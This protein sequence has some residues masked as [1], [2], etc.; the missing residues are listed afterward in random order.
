MASKRRKYKEG[1]ERLIAI[2]A[3]E[4]TITGFL[5]T[6]MG[7]VDPRKSK[8]FFV[9]D[10]KTSQSQIEEAFKRFTTRDDVGIV[11]VAQ[12]IA[13]DIRYLIKE[14]KQAIP[15]LLEIPTKDHPYDASKDSLMQRCNI[16]FGDGESS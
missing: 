14:F 1:E 13:N 2:I 16:L 6:G 7:D 4:D 8:N 9:V 3:D 11:L 12:N 15:A 10:S 5:L